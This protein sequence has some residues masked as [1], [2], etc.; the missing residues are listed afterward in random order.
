[1]NDNPY[2]ASQVKEATGRGPGKALL[3]VNCPVC[4]QEM[5]PGWL[6]M[7]NPILWLNFVVWQRLKPGYVRFSAPKDSERVIVPKVGGKGCPK[8]WIC[9]K[10]KTVTFSY[11]VENLD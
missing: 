8:A 3:E 5:K 9:T 2:L 10:C 4:H 7:F 1:V 11:A 6:A